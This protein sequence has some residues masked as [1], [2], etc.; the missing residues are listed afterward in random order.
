MRSALTF[1]LLALGVALGCG[2]RKEHPAP[3]AGSASSPRPVATA[4]TQPSTPSSPVRQEPQVAPSVPGPKLEQ[5]T[6]RG[7]GGRAVPLHPKDQAHQV[8]A[9]LA[10]A[11]VV[12][13]LQ[14]SQKSGWLRVR[15]VEGVEGWLS[16]RYVTGSTSSGTHHRATKS[17][18]THSG[19]TSLPSSNTLPTTSP[20]HSRA[21]CLSQL[22]QGHRKTLPERTFRLATWNVRWFPEGSLGQP[23]HGEGPTDLEWL[24][25]SIAW[26]QADVVAVQEFLAN[27]AAKGALTELLGL[28]KQ[29]TGSP[30][31]SRL[32]ACPGG[33]R[34]HVG[35][36][37]KEQRVV[38]RGWQDLSALNPTGET[39]CAGNLRP[40]LGGYFSFN[41]GPD[42]HL[43]SVHLKSGADA[44]AYGLRRKSWTGLAD[45]YRAVQTVAADA[46][47]IVVGD[48]NTMGC[49]DCSPVV[50]A[51]EELR[52]LEAE[53]GGAAT[54]MRHVAASPQCSEYYR[55]HGTSLDHFVV[56][57][58]MQE[59]G[60]QVSA[61]VEGYCRELQCAPAEAAT[62][63]EAYRRLSD[64]CPVLLD[65][66]CEDTD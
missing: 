25:C 32:D 56:T 9:R 51:P 52:V 38:V 18:A 60:S 54:R 17:G 42:L 64:H 15:S 48:M 29:M 49:R 59:V 35:F 37:Y 28:L 47:L 22:A 63:P 34:Q 65:V 57:E 46:D 43:V 66:S 36:L 24:A 21:S 20:W 14:R 6:L 2:V 44:R 50:L 62:M 26:M 23:Q 39:A 5:A 8:S 58:K 45:A 27:D 19:A 55:G 41:A 4:T 30:W 61:E 1:L 53:V 31:A 11:S 16:P 12:T 40:G 7:R 33:G 3:G 13:V 10:D